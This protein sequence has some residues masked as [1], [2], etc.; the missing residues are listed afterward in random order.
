M[1]HS[2]QALWV[3]AIANGDANVSVYQSPTSLY[4]FWTGN[5]GAVMSTSRRSIQKQERDQERELAKVDRKES[6]D[7]MAKFMVFNK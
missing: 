5:Q 2:Q 7:F 6:T 4:N 3:K 1:D